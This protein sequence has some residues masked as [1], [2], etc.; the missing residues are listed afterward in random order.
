MLAVA[1][2]AG[3]V[4]FGHRLKVGAKTKSRRP[5]LL[6]RTIQ[7]FSYVIYCVNIIFVDIYTYLYLWK[8]DG[9]LAALARVCLVITPPLQHR[10]ATQCKKKR[11]DGL[12]DD[13]EN[14]IDMDGMEE[15]IKFFD[16]VCSEDVRVLG[17]YNP[18]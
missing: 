11:E 16:A 2:V 10:L 12:D 14:N 6:K 7:Y 9:L 3:T 13:L 8:V 18:D 4:S 17:V 5:P 1:S 15:D